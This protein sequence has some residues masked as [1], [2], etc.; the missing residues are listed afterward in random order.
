M[1]PKWGEL[2]HLHPQKIST[3][4]MPL[5]NV[6]FALLGSPRLEWFWL[7][8]TPQDESHGWAGLR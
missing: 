4:V 6:L 7:A 1:V 3:V 2:R 5:L 8:D